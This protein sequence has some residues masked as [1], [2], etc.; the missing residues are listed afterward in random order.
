ML[1]SI[2]ETLV[3]MLELPEREFCL[4]CGRAPGE[5]FQNPEAKSTVAKIM[6]KLKHHGV[7]EDLSLAVSEVLLKIQA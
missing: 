2:A 7:T 3:W 1:N 5:V 4:E 6:K